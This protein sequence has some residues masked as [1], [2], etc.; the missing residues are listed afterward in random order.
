ML[1]LY[2]NIKKLRLELGLSQEDLA[3]KVGYK[4][5]TSIAKIESGKVDIPQSKIV[6]FAKALNTTPTQLMGWDYNADFREKENMRMFLLDYGVDIEYV[7]DPHRGEYYELV[8]YKGEAYGEVA[9]ELFNLYLE[10]RNLWS[11]NVIQHKLDDFFYSLK[12]IPKIYGDNLRIKDLSGTTVKIKIYGTIPAG[13]PLYAIE[14]IKGEIDIPAE[15]LIGDKEFIALE[16]EGDSMSPKYLAGDIVILQLSCDCESGQE[17]AV[18]VNGEDATFKKVIKGDNY[19]TLQP[20]N[21][22]Y[23]PKTFVGEQMQ[24]L[25][26]LGIAKEI[27]RRI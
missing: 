18:Y 15:W 1:E 22:A 12:K 16:I 4:D 21:Q 3:K 9:N 17:C 19:I 10:L 24:E 14:D 8:Y 25:K 7:E 26:I 27:R 20:L 23:E 5:R 6:E 11:R 13:V 2:K